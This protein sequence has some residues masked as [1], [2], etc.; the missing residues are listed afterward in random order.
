VYTDREHI[1]AQCTLLS[2]PVIRVASFTRALPSRILIHAQ[3]W[4]RGVEGSWGRGAGDAAP[5]TNG[6]DSRASTLAEDEESDR[7]RVTKAAAASGRKVPDGCLRGCG[8]KK[9]E[10]GPRNCASLRALPSQ[11]R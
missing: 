5:G 4:G 9:N 8:T 2:C 1:F 11:R 6:E 3:R 10:G 7:R